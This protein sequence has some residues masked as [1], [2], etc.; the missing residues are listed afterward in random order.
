MENA[1]ILYK[2]EVHS[3]KKHYGGESM[4]VIIILLLIGLIVFLRIYAIKA[5]GQIQ[6]TFDL[7]CPTCHNQLKERNATAYCTNCK[8]YV[9]AKES[10]NA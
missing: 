9:N 2:M 4:P 10:L 1:F 5:K 3:V 6:E 8:K 7:T